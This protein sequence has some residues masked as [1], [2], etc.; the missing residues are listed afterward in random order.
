MVAPIASAKAMR[1]RLYRL[2]PILTCLRRGHGDW[3]ASNQ[4][5]QPAASAAP[6]AEIQ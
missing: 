3:F 1:R 6:S 2:E 5:I 4:L